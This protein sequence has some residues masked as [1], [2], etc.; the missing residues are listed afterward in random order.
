MDDIAEEDEAELAQIVRQVKRIATLTAPDKEKENKMPRLGL[1]GANDS[2]GDTDID[3]QWQVV[4][5]PETNSEHSSRLGVIS[6]SSP[7]HQTHDAQ[8]SPTETV[9]TW[10]CCGGPDDGSTMV[11]CEAENC[12]IGWWHLE[13]LELKEAPQEGI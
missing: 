4:S 5:S 12:E 7:E 10:C 2:D 9:E 6:V 11:A 13:C 8:H 3:Q 1:D